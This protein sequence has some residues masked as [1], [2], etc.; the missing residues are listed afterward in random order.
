VALYIHLCEWVSFFDQVV[1]PTSVMRPANFCDGYC[2]AVIQNRIVAFRWIYLL[3]SPGLCI[4]SN[5]LLAGTDLWIDTVLGT[6]LPF[7]VVSDA[8]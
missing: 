5:L 2:I 8:P 6:S 3:D 1:E 4:D 7:L